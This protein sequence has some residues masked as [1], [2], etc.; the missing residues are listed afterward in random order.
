M[1][2]DKKLSNL[3]ESLEKNKES[4]NNGSIESDTD[5]SSRNRFWSNKEKV[6][7]VAI[8]V[9]SFIVFCFAVS[10]DSQENVE[11]KNTVNELTSQT[12]NLQ[13]Q[14]SNLTQEVNKKDSTINETKSEI[15]ELKKE[16]NELKEELE[17]KED[18]EKQDQVEEKVV[19][20][21]KSTVSESKDSNDDEEKSYTYILNKNTKVFH[22]SG[23]SSVSRMKD[24]N[25][26]EFTGT[27]T[28][29]INKG[30]KPCGN[31]H[32]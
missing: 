21:S 3:I 13:N 5:T 23:C 25:K 17:Q 11:L 12:E 14:I 30:Y 27:R 1:D 2:D 15:E 19:D 20:T 22:V 4:N 26:L 10:N 29:V 18:S 32:P 9:L 8:C 31:C 7:T 28:E 16:N 24:S 6:K